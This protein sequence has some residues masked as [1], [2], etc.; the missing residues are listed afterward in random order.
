MVNNKGGKKYKRS[1]NFGGQE[2]RQLLLPE[3]EFQIYA[4]VFKK[5]GRLS[6]RN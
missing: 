1:K 4:K 6:F 3:G 5:I 2:D